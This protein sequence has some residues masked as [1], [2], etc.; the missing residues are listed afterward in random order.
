[1]AVLFV[2]T[3]LLSAQSGTEDL[4]LR[5]EQAFKEEQYGEAANLYQEAAV[6]GAVSGELYYNQGNSWFM[7]GESNRALLSYLKGAALLPGD[8]DIRKN[9]S[10]L[11]ARSGEDINNRGAGEFIRVL[12]FWHFDLSPRL[13]GILFLIVNAL[14]WLGVTG[15]VLLR[16][17]YPP[18]KIILPFLGIIL[19]SLAISLFIQEYQLRYHPKGVILTDVTAQKGDGLQYEEAFN[20]PLKGGTEF[21]LIEKRGDWYHILLRDG[22]DG[23]VPDTSTGLVNFP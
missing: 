6:R 20:R 8:S 19:L 10:F 16:K 18:F 1:M 13:R 12:F 2:L 3:F 17:K 7:A 22:T 5:A 4:I 21:K 14:F 15:A 9:L 11:R 23:W